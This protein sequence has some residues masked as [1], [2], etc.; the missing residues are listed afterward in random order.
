MCSSDLLE[1]RAAFEKACGRPIP[2]ELSAR[3]PGDV[4]TC[5]ADASR[6][7]DKL[8]W[9]A[10][11]GLAEM[12]SDTW[13]LLID[14]LVRRSMERQGYQFIRS[15]ELSEPKGLMHVCAKDGTKSAL[16]CLANGAFFELAHIRFSVVGAG[17]T[18]GYFWL[19][20]VDG[21]VPIGGGFSFPAGPVVGFSLSTE[22]IPEPGTLAL[23]ALGS[24][25]KIVFRPDESSRLRLS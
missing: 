6:A 20:G 23:L 1:M 2:Y 24:D 18:G 11:L 22:P 25:P 21:Q 17:T 3:R 10:N 12:T 16:L 19:P 5:F 9:Q 7:K 13:R 14:Q 15:D 4:A 8:G